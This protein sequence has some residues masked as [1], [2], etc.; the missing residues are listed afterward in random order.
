MT[1]QTIT[2]TTDRADMSGYYLIHR[3]MATGLELIAA[4]VANAT[5]A[6]RRRQL[7]ALA[8][9]TKGFIDELRGH[10]NAEDHIVMPAVRERAPAIEEHLKLYEADHRELEALLEE[11][12]NL[13]VLLAEPHTP[14]RPV[15][16]RATVATERLRDLVVPHMEHENIHLLPVIAQKFSKAEYEA[17]EEE[18]AKTLKFG[19][20]FWVVPWIMDNATPAEQ[21]HLLENA[22][23]ILKLIYR[24]SRRRYARLTKRAF[25]STTVTVPER[26]MAK[27]A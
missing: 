23:G 7:P 19:H 6:D 11:V 17:I 16:F 12:D 27:V 18:I 8:T 26:A 22:P 5:E 13:V 9:W 14:W 24:V 20:A 4:T 15:H 3:A 10:H 1:Q 21:E 25:A 2:S